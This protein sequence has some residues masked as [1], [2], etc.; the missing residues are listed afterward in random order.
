M[1]PGNHDSRNV[2]YKHFERIWGRHNRVIRKNGITLV[3]VDSTEPD[4]DYGRVG[5]GV[6]GWLRDSL[7]ERPDDF[8]PSPTIIC[9]LIPAPVERNVVHDAGDAGTAAGAG[10]ASCC[11]AT[12]MCR[13][14]GAWRVCIS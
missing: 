13:M 6:A 10:E 7:L 8:R 1:V 14:R 3:G 9:F 11:R 5:R 12:S 2:G 4:L